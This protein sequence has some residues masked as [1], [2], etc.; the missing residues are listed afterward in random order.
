MESP[1]HEH[2]GYEEGQTTGVLFSSPEK[3]SVLRQRHDMILRQALNPEESA[4][5]I[6]EL[7]EE[8]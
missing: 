8:L 1:E 5:L 6:N 3:V 7:A 2:F 4:R